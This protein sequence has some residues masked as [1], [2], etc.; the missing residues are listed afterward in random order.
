MDPVT[1]IPLPQI[2][3]PEEYN[4]NYILYW[5]HIGL[6]LNRLTHTVGG[7]QTG[8]PIS[9]RALGML[10]LAAH[11]AYFA[12]NPSAE[13]STFL[14]PGAENAEYRLPDLNGADDAR[15]AV[16]GASLKM[17]TELYMKP[18]VQSNPNPGANISDRAYAQLALFIEQSSAEAPGGVDRASASF[19]F[20]EAVADVFFKLIIHPPGGSP[21]PYH[22]TPGP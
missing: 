16:A 19:L 20:G 1:P 13:F 6:E 12:I 3:E 11:D 21:P 4:T 2:D 9:A 10:Q 18:V 7:P 22:P 15:Q 5:H 17:L 14:T 8:P